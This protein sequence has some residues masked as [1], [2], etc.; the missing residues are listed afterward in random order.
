[1]NLENRPDIRGDR[2]LFGRFSDPSSRSFF[3]ISLFILIIAALFRFTANDIRPFH[4]DEAVQ[5]IKFVDLLENGKYQYDPHEY[6]GPTLVYATLVAAKLLGISQSSELTESFLRF[7]PALFGLLLLLQT[8]YLRKRLGNFAVLTILLLIALSPAMTFYSRYYIQEMLLA[9]FSGAF[10]LIIIDHFSR[11]RLQ[12]AALAACALALMYTSKETFILPLFAVIT[13]GGLLWWQLSPA[14]RKNY[15]VKPAFSLKFSAAFLAVFF[16]ISG[17]F[18]SSFGDNPQGM[19]DAITT[20]FSTYLEKGVD[21][22]W[23]VHPWY[24]YLGMLLFFQKGDGF[25]WS[26]AIILLLAA[27]GVIAAFRK[28]ALPQRIQTIARFLA[29]YA[30]LLTFFYSLIPYKTPWNM[31]CFF[32]AVIIVAGIGATAIYHNCQPHWLR[33]LLLGVFAFGFT[34]LGYQ[35]YRVNFQDYVTNTNP[36]VYGHPTSDVPKAAALINDIARTDTSAGATYIQF[37]FPGNDYWPFPWYL[38]MLP[39]I[40]WWS[41]V[42]EN[43]PTAP[44]ILAAPEMEKELLNLLY[45][46]PPPGQ[47]HLYLPLFDEVMYLRPGVE[48]RG[49]IRQDLWEKYRNKG[50]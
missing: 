20:Y 8:F 14:E 49:Y 39:N 40:G 37:V 12:S 10:L 7:I 32:H 31:L 19:S 42:P 28:N 2:T 41:A 27:A 23:H 22:Q 15:S 45:F 48:M 47:R 4:G 34:H 3:L 35:S 38:R 1:M 43:A 46:K 18:F 36:H 44:L 6:H 5:G 13:A 26:E 17:I 50:E 29:L 16:F 21:H 9:C 25:I 11:P 33:M 30:L 24:Y